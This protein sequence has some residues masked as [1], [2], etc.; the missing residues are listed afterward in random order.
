MAEMLPIYQIKN[1]FY[2]L[3]KRL[4]EYRNIKN[5]ND[6]IDFN[7]FPKLQKGTPNSNKRLAKIMRW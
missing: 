6:R 2:F 5:P 7:T 3:D 4:G 1:K